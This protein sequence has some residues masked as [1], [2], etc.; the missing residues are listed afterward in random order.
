MTQVMQET[1]KIFEHKRTAFLKL[2]LHEAINWEKYNLMS[3]SHHSTAIEGSSLTELESQLLLEEGTTPKGKPLEHSL[4][5]KDHYNAFCFIV[6]EAKKKKPV[7]PDLIR[8]VSSI[9]MKNTGGPVSA[10]G[11]DFDSS[12]GE[13]RKAS[14][15]AGA[16]YFPSY[17]KVEGMVMDLCEKL[18]NK[19]DEVS[20]TEDIYNLAFDFHFN[21]VSIHPFADG[22]GR[23]SRLMMNYILLYHKLIP[24]IIHK[25]DKEEYINALEES[26]QEENSS[27]IRKFLYNQQV[28][29]YDLLI[30]AY[31]SRDKGISL[32]L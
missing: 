11:G 5:E 31:N 16:R 1:L 25:E 21:L 13:Y 32:V 6:D 4:M 27:P 24:A 30:E 9:V 26:R 18:T 3:L 8:K 12:K 23:V 28:K 19:I 22:N 2:K 15:F 10:G 20:D 17:T 7:T 14:V 29:H